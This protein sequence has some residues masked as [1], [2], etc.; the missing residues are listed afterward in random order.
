VKQ[1]ILQ[2]MKIAQPLRE[3]TKGEVMAKT[4]AKQQK[5]TNTTRDEKNRSKQQ[6]TDAGGPSQTALSQRQQSVPGLFTNPFS[7][8]RRF[9]E[10]MEQLFAEFGAGGLMHRGFGDI[11][12]WTPQVEMFQREGQLIIRADLPGLRKE[13]V[14]VELRDDSVIIRGERQEERKEE[15]EGFYSTER[16]YGRFY[17]EV[18]LPPGVDVDEATANFNDG[19]LEIAMPAELVTARGRQ[20]EIQESPAAEQGKQKAQAAGGSR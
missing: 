12:A 3:V 5:A 9:G 20:L 6:R 1:F 14:Q 13:D 4:E 15:R 10:G 8:M 11:A 7:F 16:S 17:R 18:P 19:V 2:G